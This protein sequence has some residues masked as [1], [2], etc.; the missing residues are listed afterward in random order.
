MSVYLVR[1]GKA[2]ERAAWT[3]DDTLRPLSGR[4]RRQAGAI[5][6]R[7]EHENVTRLVSSPA[8]RCVQT[9]EPLAERVG[10]PIN[11]D[12]RLAEGAAIEDTLVLIDE[13]P[14]GG[15]MCTHGDVVEQ[16]I[17]AL[18]R[19]GMKLLGVPDWRK[20]ATWVIDT[21]AEGI[22]RAYALPPPDRDPL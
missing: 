11:E 22:Q 13:L 3:G 5:A 7:M 8:R 1:H 6:E 2:G 17:T 16:T 21:D 4:G 10:L 12:H 19:R 15:V 9:L 14:D 18:E 20:G